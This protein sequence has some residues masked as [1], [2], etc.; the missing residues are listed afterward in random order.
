MVS[1]W[2]PSIKE[3]RLFEGGSEGEVAGVS[4]EV[5]WAEAI[6]KHE[7]WGS[8]ETVDKCVECGLMGRSPK[9]WGVFLG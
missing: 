5:E 8:G 9:E 7:D 6:W 1:D 3:V 4:D 2:V